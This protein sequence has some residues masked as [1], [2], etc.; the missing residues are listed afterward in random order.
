M[1]GLT[2]L[3]PLNQLFVIIFIVNL[4]GR[5]D[6]SY[7]IKTHVLGNSRDLRKRGTFSLEV[8]GTT[9]AIRVQDKTKQEHG[10]IT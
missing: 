6:M 2:H 4:V 8:D 10:G 3:D 7:S 5:R 1:I 9:T